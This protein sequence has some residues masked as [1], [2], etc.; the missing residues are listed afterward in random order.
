VFQSEYPGFNNALFFTLPEVDDE[1]CT[2]VGCDNLP[3]ISPFYSEK[4][5]TMPTYAKPITGKLLSF[6]KENKTTELPEKP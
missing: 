2:G 6:D 5:M 4:F 1:E 3:S